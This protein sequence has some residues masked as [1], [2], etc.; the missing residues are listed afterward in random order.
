MEGGFTHSDV[1]NM[2]IYLRNFY[3]QKLIKVKKD[4]QK[5]IKKSQSKRPRTGSKFKR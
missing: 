3:Y 1:Y 5:Q 4:E 2:P